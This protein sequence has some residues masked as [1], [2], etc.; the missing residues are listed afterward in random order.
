MPLYKAFGRRDFLNHACPGSRAL[1]HT[2]GPWRM[3]SSST[4]SSSVSRVDNS[5]SRRDSVNYDGKGHGVAGHT[6]KG[7]ATES[8]ATGG[9]GGV[10]D[11]G[12]SSRLC[13]GPGVGRRAATQFP[14]GVGGML[15]GLC[16]VA[17]RHWKRHC[18]LECIIEAGIQL[19]A[20]CCCK[21]HHDTPALKTDFLRNPS[22]WQ[23]MAPRTLTL[24]A[25]GA[26]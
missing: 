1:P 10:G 20:G 22:A 17:C 15:T 4:I 12:N 26:F 23:S 3:Y 6:I 14:A 8:I 13:V 5:L 2:H 16:G 9:K 7:A 25:V 18:H 24:S 11:A 19:C 21:P